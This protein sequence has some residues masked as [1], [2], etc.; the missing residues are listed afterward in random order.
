MSREIK[1]RAWRKDKGEWL[2]LMDLPNNF[3]SGN[4]ILVCQFTELFEIVQYTGLKDKNGKEIYEG[5]IIEYVGGLNRPRNKVVVWDERHLRWGLKNPH[6]SLLGPDSLMPGLATKSMEVIGNIYENPEL[7]T[8]EDEDEE[9]EYD[10]SMSVAD[11]MLDSIQ[12]DG[13]LDRAQDLAEAILDELSGEYDPTSR[14][15]LDEGVMISRTKTL[16]LPI[17]EDKEVAIH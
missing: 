6:E 8:A 10:P 12:A 7:L 14:L 11:L 3:H 2:H 16:N 9:E 15:D 1:L 13:D 17:Y 5:D 4:L